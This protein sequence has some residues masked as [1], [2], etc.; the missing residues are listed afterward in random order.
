MNFM[1]NERQNYIHMIVPL[2]QKA[3]K[4]EK[5]FILDHGIQVLAMNRSYLAHCLS[6]SHRIIRLSDKVKFRPMYA[7]KVFGS[8]P[9]SLP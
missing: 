9:A 6:Q 7:K 8:V 3:S 5:S 4:K 1:L 2:Y